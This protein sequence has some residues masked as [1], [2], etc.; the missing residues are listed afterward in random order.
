MSCRFIFITPDD[1]KNR[2][3]ISNN[4][5][6]RY[7]IPYAALA[8]DKS[9]K[10]ILCNDLYAELEEQSINNTLTDANQT[11]IDDYI[12]PF[13]VF[14]TY[15]RYL[16]YANYKSTPAGIA[17]T[18]GEDYE[19]A[20]DAAISMMIRQASDDAKYYE[21]NLR[22]FLDDNKDTYPLWRDNCQCEKE[23]TGSFSITSVGG[24]YNKKDRRNKNSRSEW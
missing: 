18:K 21:N 23:R 4:V 11:L 6:P 24:K 8:Q 5:N 15:E 19:L 9:L 7:V 2:V 12:K 10:G 16:A 20:S 3:D 22:L 17:S 1:Y 13:L 14:K